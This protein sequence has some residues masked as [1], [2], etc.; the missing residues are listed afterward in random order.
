MLIQFFK[1]RKVVFRVF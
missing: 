1:A